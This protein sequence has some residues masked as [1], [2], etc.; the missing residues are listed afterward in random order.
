MFSGEVQTTNY[1][2]PQIIAGEE[3]IIIC[4]SATIKKLKIFPWFCSCKIGCKTRNLINS[5]WQIHC[6]IFTSFRR[7]ET[8]IVIA[9][10]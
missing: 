4:K 10:W 8:N 1:T 2:E 3:L 6:C 7:I 9:H 5:G